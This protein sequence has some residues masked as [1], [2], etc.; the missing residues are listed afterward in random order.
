MPASLH[1]QDGGLGA[2]VGAGLLV[3]LLSSFSP[4]HWGTASRTVANAGAT[5]ARATEASKLATRVLG[6]RFMRAS[7]EPRVDSVK[8]ASRVRSE[9]ER[10]T[11]GLFAG[12]QWLPLR[13]ACC[14]RG[15]LVRL[16]LLRGGAG[17]MT[18]PITLDPRGTGPFYQSSRPGTLA[19]VGPR[20]DESQHEV[21]DNQHVDHD[22]RRLQ[23][24]RMAD[25]LVNFEG[26]ERAGDHRRQIFGPPFAQQ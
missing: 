21:N 18:Q 16:W 23:Y 4:P 7:L 1:A 8:R 25:H 13:T 22:T 2:G 3:P 5:E 15:E 26:N 24:R 17:E 19:A 6:R 14:D 10:C 11:S 12:A 9:A 20:F